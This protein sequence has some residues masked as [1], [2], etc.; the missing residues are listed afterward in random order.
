MDLPFV[1]ALEPAHRGALRDWRPGDA[2]LGGGTWLFS[3]PQPQLRR[4]LD[5]HAFGWEPLTVSEAGL[6]IAATCTLAE[7]AA[8]QPPSRWPAGR[9]LRQACQA[10]QASFKIWN[11]ATVGGNICLSL[12][13]G[14][15]TSLAAS[16]DGVCT[17]WRADGAVEAVPAAVFVTGAGENVLR[18]GELLR[19]VLLPERALASRTAF[20]QFSRT[21]LGRS[22][23]VVIGRRDPDDGGVVI[24]VTAAVTRPWQARFAGVPSAG[25]LEAALAG[26]ELDYFD[27][28]HGSRAWRAHL[29]NIL[30]EQVRAELDEAGA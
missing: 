7:L 26:A 18:P 2:W 14:A 5:L 1:E 9:L 23:A 6:E 27:D 25:E 22:A 11:E 29:T 10:L 8:L 30:C 19:A 17:I 24:T 20:R 13:A 15:I 16:L 21:P 28:P 12:P 3:E 4:L